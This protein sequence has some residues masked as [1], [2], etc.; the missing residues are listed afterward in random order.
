MIVF[1]TSAI[2]RMY[3]MTDGAK[4]TM[5]DIL[6]FFKGQIWIPGHVWT[7]YDR[8]RLKVIRNSIID[9]YP[10]LKW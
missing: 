8:N 3:D 7:E 1:D 6:D 9:H 5:M 4:K 2:C 10:K